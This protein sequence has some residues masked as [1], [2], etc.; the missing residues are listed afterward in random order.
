MLLALVATAAADR[1]PTFDERRDVARAVDLPTKCAKVRIST[2]TPEP[3]WATALW[4]PGPKKCEGY[5][6]NGVSVLKVN[7]NG[8]WRFV[9]AGSDFTCSEL[10]RDVPKPIVRDLEIACRRD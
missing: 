9:T 3:K 10:Y 8:H 7:R 4:T 6:S 5:A 1:A 2:A